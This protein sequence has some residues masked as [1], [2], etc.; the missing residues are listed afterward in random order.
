MHFW[1]TFHCETCIFYAFA[2]NW[3]TVSIYMQGWTLAP[4]CSLRATHVLISNFENYFYSFA[5][6]TFFSVNQQRRQTETHTVA[7]DAASSAWKLCN[8]GCTLEENWGS[9]LKS[10]SFFEWCQHDTEIWKV[11]GIKNVELAG[12]KSNEYC[13]F[14]YV[15]AF[16]HRLLVFSIFSLYFHSRLK[17]SVTSRSGVV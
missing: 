17:Y 11:K 12:I 4:T 9:R 2:K 3:N 1:C 10:S 8:D 6:V 15:L 16:F 5:F 14:R 13:M 7:I